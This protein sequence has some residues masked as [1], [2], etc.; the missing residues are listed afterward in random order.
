MLT[1]RSSTSLRYR[2]YLLNTNHI[3]SAPVD[4]IDYAALPTTDWRFTP[5]PRSVITDASFEYAKWEM[6]NM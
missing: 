4:N 2:A 3:T 5:L 6:V 1:S